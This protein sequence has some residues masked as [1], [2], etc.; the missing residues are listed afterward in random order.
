M[1]QLP[2]VAFLIVGTTVSGVQRHPN[3]LDPPQFAAVDLR[4][5]SS[6]RSLAASLP[7]SPPPLQATAKPGRSTSRTI[8]GGALGLVVGGLAGGIVGAKIGGH[9]SNDG[10]IAGVAVGLPVGGLTGML[11]GGYFFGR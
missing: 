1:L 4:T 11:I 2:I 5:A 8:I 9:N 6:S 3:H 10:D 7:L